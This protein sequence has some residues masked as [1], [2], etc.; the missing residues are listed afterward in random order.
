MSR[1]KENGDD[2]F[3]LAKGKVGMKIFPRCAS[4]TLRETYGQPKSKAEALKKPHVIV[5][6]RNPWDRLLSVFN[7]MICKNAAEGL[8]ALGYPPK[9]QEL[10][11]LLE[12][13]IET[14]S[15]YLDWHTRPMWDQMTGYQPESEQIYTTEQVIAHPP[16][17]LN[18]VSKHHHKTPDIMKKNRQY[19]SDLFKKW[20]EKYSRDWWMYL[21]A[22]ARD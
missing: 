1:P 4:T 3:W 20:E 19:S 2:K 7:G 15:E 11:G 18:K 6:V 10:D 12:Y 21:T 9:T 22:H 13:L 5:I 8:K 14:P 17:G 16:F